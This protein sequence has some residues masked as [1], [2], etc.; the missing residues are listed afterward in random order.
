[1]IKLDER[2][3]LEAIN[4]ND[5]DS[6]R[7]LVELELYNSDL[8]TTDK[9][10]INAFK[11]FAK[12]Q[13]KDVRISMQGAFIDKDNLITVCDGYRIVKLFTDKIVGCDMVDMS[14]CHTLV[15]SAKLMN[16]TKSSAETQIN[17]DIN[18]VMVQYKK[19]KSMKGKTPNAENYGIYLI[20]Y[21]GFK[22]KAYMS[23]NIEYLK[24]THDILDF[25]KDIE[26]YIAD[27][28]NDKEWSIADDNGT[29]TKKGKFR[30]NIDPL[31]IISDNG[32]SLILPIRIKVNPLT[33]IENNKK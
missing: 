29:V 2:K 24:Q 6:I 17:I 18:E 22:G 19:Y 25:T 10:R 31:M 30:E 12:S 9:R 13:L 14:K 20:E 4:N 32:E 27:K 1:M 11:K 8:S 3:V 16:D 5:L 33:I 26:F 28:T 15:D 23:I 21:D 7:K